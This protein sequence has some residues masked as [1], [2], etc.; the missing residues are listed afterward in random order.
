MEKQAQALRNILFV[1]LYALKVSLVC[2]LR[3][4][5]YI[6]IEKPDDLNVFVY[7]NTEV[8]VLV[9]GSNVDQFT[10]FKRLVALD[11]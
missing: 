4:A 3:I 11:R 8:F 5:Y 6:V 2:Y 9:H 10:Q 7:P 1:D